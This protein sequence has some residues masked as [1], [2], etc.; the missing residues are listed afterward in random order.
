MI[1]QARF[2]GDFFGTYSGKFRESGEANVNVHH[3][4]R[5]GI[6]RGNDSWASNTFYVLGKIVGMTCLSWQ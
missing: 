5:L 4:M 6:G 2:P 1:L 3:T